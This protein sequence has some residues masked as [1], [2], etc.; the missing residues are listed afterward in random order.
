MPG[1]LNLLPR[2]MLVRRSRHRRIRQWVAVLTLESLLVGGAC[3]VLRVD[4]EDPGAEARDTIGST[5]GQIDV[6][7]SAL[8]A[9]QEELQSVQ[10]RLAVASEVASKPDWSIVLAALAWSGQGLTTLDSIQ[11]LPPMTDTETGES[12]YRLTLLGECSSRRDLTRF[13]QS[14]EET[15]LFSAVKIVET[16]RVANPDN[17]RMP[18]VG[19]MIEARLVAGGA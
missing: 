5:V 7:S 1:F 11:L 13:V 15:K 19:F 12:S 16:Q 6:V 14:L 18:R 4:F 17:P 3:V 2:S 10:Q 8:A 9:S